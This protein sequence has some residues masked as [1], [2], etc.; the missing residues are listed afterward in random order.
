SQTYNNWEVLAVDDHS[1][2][3][4]RSLVESLSKKE[5]RIKVFNNK[6]TGIIPA[7]RTAYSK[8]KGRLISRMDS[9]D[10]MTP[11]KLQVM[12]DSLLED[13]K[14]HLAVGQVKYFSDHGVGHGY[15]RYE[16]WLNALT[17][18]GN[19]FS[20]I[21]KECVIPSPCWMVF[22][23][24]LDSC[25]A[26]EPDRY[27]EDYDLTFR[28]YEQGLKCIPCNQIL[29]LW[30]DYETR[31]SRTSEHYA[32]NYFLDIKLHYFLKLEYNPDRPL[33]LWGAGNKGKEI[34][35]GLQKQNIAFHWLCDN[36]KKIGKEIYGQAMLHYSAL[37]VL[38]NPQSIITVANEE[39]QAMIKEYFGKLGQEHR[40]D[41]YFFC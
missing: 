35:K 19:N 25:G 10:I 38:E 13:G 41:Y 16:K 11:K 33:T 2:D 22:R 8:S 30:R 5:T 31:T 26:F 23:D 14:G 17:E 15:A 3:T 27:P 29:H 7:L 40:S 12:V 1:S 21:Y 34:A 24:D 9:D 4:C 20:E 32:Q 18:T 37:K 28:F 36:P 6:G 39:A